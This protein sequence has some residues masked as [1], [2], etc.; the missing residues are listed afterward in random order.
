M[1][2]EG[3]DSSKD[4]PCRHKTVETETQQGTPDTQHGEEGRGGGKGLAVEEDRELP[5]QCLHSHYTGY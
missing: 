3:Q 5:V 4:P 2:Q 1:A